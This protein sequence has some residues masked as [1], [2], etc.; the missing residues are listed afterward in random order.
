MCVCTKIHIFSD[1]GVGCVRILGLGCSIWLI[2][3]RV[4]LDFGPRLLDVTDHGTG[5]VRI[6]GP[7][8]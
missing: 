8:S 6:L 1:Y 4:C 5:C 7:G 3:E 2:L